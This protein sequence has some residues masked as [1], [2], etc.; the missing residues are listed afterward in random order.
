LQ[1]INRHKAETGD[2]KSTTKLFALMAAAGSLSL[3]PVSYAQ[4]NITTNVPPAVPR[5]GMRGMPV[6][7]E[8]ARLTA[9][10]K[11][12]DEQK[13]KVK[14]VLEER[15]KKLLE[16]RSDSAVPRED[17]RAKVQ[18]IR[19][20]ASKKIKE[21]LTEEQGRQYDETQQGGRRGQAGPRPGAGA[22]PPGGSTPPTP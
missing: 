18:A 4:T 21:V 14:A 9:Q 20:D 11:L 13:P 1:P 8:L 5:Q 3:S 6:E 12:T 7:N 17:I 15:N 10:L 19:E 2:M 16:L 22:P